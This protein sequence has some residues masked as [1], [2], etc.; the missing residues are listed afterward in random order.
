MRGRKGLRWK[1]VAKK[2]LTF[3]DGM[4]Q[5]EEIVRML[6]QGQMPL[7]ESL[8]AFE[9]AMELQKSLKAILD[10]G[11]RRIRVLTED[12]ERELAEEAS[13]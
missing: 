8:K 4:Q 10:D 3:E 11:D 7:E 12:G 2:K 5:L 13:E 1:G 9:K 6:E